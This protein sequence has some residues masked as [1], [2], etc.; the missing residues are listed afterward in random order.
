MREYMLLETA[1]LAVNSRCGKHARGKAG[2]R[3]LLG[4]TFFSA[5]NQLLA[6]RPAPRG[7]GEGK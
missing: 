6:Y 3:T 2:L 1:A 7:V 4:Q 5:G